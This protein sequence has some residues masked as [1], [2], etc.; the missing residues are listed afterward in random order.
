M[1]GFFGSATAPSRPRKGV[2]VFIQAALQLKERIPEL[3]LFLRGQSWD[4]DAAA[5]RQAGLQVFHPG[6]LPARQLPAAYRSLDAY[7]I[8]STNEGGPV[9]ALECMASGVPLVSTS[10]GMVRD[11]VRDREQALIVPTGQPAALAE[12]IERL[13]GDPDLCACLQE[14]ALTLVRERFLWEQVAPLY[15]DLYRQAAAD[16]PARSVSAD[17]FVRQRRSQLQRDLA[18]FRSPRAMASCTGRQRPIDRRAPCLPI[19][20]SASAG[21]SF[22]GIWLCSWAIPGTTSTTAEPCASC[23]MSPAWLRSCWSCGA[24]WS[25]GSGSYPICCAGKYNL[26]LPIS[27]AAGNRGRGNMAWQ[28]LLPG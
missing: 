15:G 3:W 23:R 22:S 2:D 11:A 25:W 18:V 12:A 5:M 4:A 24:A 28:F 9:T 14:N 20:S 1:V 8:A 6:F 10:V 26:V 27:G 17:P 13:Y 19:R 16:R 7:V 21:P